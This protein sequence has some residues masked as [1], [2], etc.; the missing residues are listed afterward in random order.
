[1]NA[2][3]HE[4]ILDLA[5]F[6]AV[7]AKL[8]DGVRPA[9]RHDGPA[10][11]AGLAR[12]A[13]CGH[14][15]SRGNSSGR[16]SYICHGDHSGERCPCAAAISCARLDAHIKSIALPELALLEVTASAGDRVGN[17]QAALAAAE[18]E[19]AAYLQ[20][21]SAADVG[22]EAFAAG[23]RNRR[24]AVDAARE[25]LRAELSRA[26]SRRTSAAAPMH[27]RISTL[28]S[29]TPSYT[30]SSPRWSSAR[31]AVGER[32]P[33]TIRVRV[34]AHGTELDLP[35]NGGHE[36]GGDRPDPVPGR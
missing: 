21:V 22:T 24:D 11:L 3:A 9:R 10:L 32:C 2:T 23:A 19:L 35:R 1:V 20:A 30:A 5:T 15:M 6:E 8:S 26:R 18:R 31:P 12:C 7:Q 17:A 16:P 33:S 13:S 28:T 34:L 4:P 36:P 27:G 29:A 25:G 14:V